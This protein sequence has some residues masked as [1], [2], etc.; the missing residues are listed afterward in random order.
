MCVQT[1]E[2]VIILY[3]LNILVGEKDNIYVYINKDE[4]GY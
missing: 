2:T 4:I 3:L 1:L